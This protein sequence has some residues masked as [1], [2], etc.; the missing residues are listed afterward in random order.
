[1]NL[2]DISSQNRSSSTKSEKAQAHDNQPMKRFRDISKIFK[3]VKA[4]RKE[5]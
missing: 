3:F 5:L 4:A 1:M 2:I